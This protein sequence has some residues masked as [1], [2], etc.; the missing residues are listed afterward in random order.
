MFLHE[1]DFFGDDVCSVTDQIFIA[2]PW[3]GFFCVVIEL[4][5]RDTQAE[6][7]QCL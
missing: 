7:G 4:L 5:E 3:R 2:D 6:I 1:P